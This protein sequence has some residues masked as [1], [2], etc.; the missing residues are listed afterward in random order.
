MHIKSLE[1]RLD[2]I[3]SRQIN[4]LLQWSVS[5]LNSSHGALESYAM[6]SLD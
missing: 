6:R 3:E 2:N 1:E 5:S 4:N